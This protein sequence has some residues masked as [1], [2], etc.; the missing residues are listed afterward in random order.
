MRDFIKRVVRR[1]LV[2]QL[3]D[4]VKRTRP[5]GTPNVSDLWHLTKDIELIKLNIK[6]L[7]YQLARDLRSQLPQEPVTSPVTLGL[8]SRAV[9][10]DE[11][12]APHFRYW[13][14]ELDIPIIFHRKIW[15]YVFA[16]QTMHDCGMLKP[17]LRALGFGCG[18]EPLP[19][20]LARRGLSVTVTDLHPDKVRDMGWTETGQHSDSLESLYHPHLV[21]RDRFN[22]LVS[23]RYVDMNDI[24]DDLTGYDVNWSIC[25]LEHLGSIDKGLKFIEN[26]LRTLRRGGVAIHTT[27]FNYLNN[28]E[29]VDNWMTVLFQR[30]H[31]EGLAARLSQLGHKVA[32]LDFNVGKGPLDHFIDLPPFEWSRLMEAATRKAEP[33]QE[34]HLKLAI[35]GFAS[36]CFGIVVTK[37]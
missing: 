23:L 31:F 26:S 16:L 27:E 28:D 5:D 21:D 4:L 2:A 37:A 25:S 15:E 7:G 30:K 20:Y 9:T 3:P 12:S 33:N 32:P 36:T 19:S 11:F 13:C 29:T 24:P 1:L 17:G 6:S 22:E 35:D 10:Q 34:A 8:S 18:Q 14:A